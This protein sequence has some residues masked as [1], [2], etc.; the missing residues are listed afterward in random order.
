MLHVEQPSPVTQ[1]PQKHVDMRLVESWLTD[2][3]QGSRFGWN[4]LFMVG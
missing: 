1:L 4:L 3:R 2:L